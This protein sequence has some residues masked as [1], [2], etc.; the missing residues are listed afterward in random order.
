MVPPISLS[1]PTSA[2]S[3]TGIGSLAA[4]GPAQAAGQ[5]NFEDLLW[6][7]IGEVNR[8]D[9]SSQAAIAE[10]LGG[11]EITQAEVLAGMRKADLAMRMLMQVRN[12]LLDAYRE[13]QQMRM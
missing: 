11:G 12:K 2:H 13:V 10:S 1:G 3:A 5:P 9:S 4:T 8:L 7:S 6:K